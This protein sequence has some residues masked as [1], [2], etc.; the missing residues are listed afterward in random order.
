M[1]W[2]FIS[3]KAVNLEGVKSISIRGQEVDVCYGLGIM[4]S[5]RSLQFWSDKGE[6]INSKDLVINTHLFYVYRVIK[7][8]R[9]RVVIRNNNIL[10]MLIID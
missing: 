7:P 3:I 5:D 2:K 8:K 9:N 10:H 1:K 6:G 4:Y